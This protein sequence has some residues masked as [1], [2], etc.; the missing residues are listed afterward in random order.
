M[1]LCLCVC[2]C[3]CLN[4]RDTTG[5][6]RALVYRSL[7]NNPAKLGRAK[8]EISIGGFR[9]L[10][11]RAIEQ[12]HGNLSVPPWTTGRK[13]ASGWSDRSRSI[14]GS[15][16]DRLAHT[17]YSTWQRIEVPEDCF[18]GCSNASPV[19]VAPFSRSR[20]LL[21]SATCH[22]TATSTSASPPPVWQPYG[23]PRESDG[24]GKTC[25]GLTT[26]AGKLIAD[27]NEWP[28]RTQ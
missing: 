18:S 20:T 23:E 6:F 28:N 1:S 4:D 12:P 19:A 22:S 14:A 5:Q 15:R 21:S 24:G 9:R 11:A 25:I 13:I 3:V 8:D 10:V 7:L 26:C 16:V 27:R 17:R 2:V